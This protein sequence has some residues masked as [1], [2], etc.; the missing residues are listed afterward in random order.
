VIAGSAT[1]GAADGY[2]SQA[3]FYN[4]YFIHLN[5]NGA[6]F[7]PDLSNNM[8]RKLDTAGQ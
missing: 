8:V 6:I 4:I 2:G 5:T 1:T 3:K 7:V